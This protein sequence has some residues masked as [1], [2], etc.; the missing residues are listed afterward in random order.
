MGR[1]MATDNRRLSDWGYGMQQ[2]GLPTASGTQDWINQQPFRQQA[3]TPYEFNKFQSQVT[4]ENGQWMVS[5]NVRFFEPEDLRIKTVGD[6]VE[7]NAKHNEKQDAEGSVCRELLE[8]I[9][10]QK[11]STHWMLNA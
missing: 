1:E 7:I 10:C 8:N 2:S 3:N 6:Q 9:T 5:L 11:E 4:T